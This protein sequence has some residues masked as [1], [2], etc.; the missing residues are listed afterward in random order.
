MPNL[1]MA[2]AQFCK[3]YEIMIIIDGDD[4]LLGKQGFKFY[5]AIFQKYDIWIMY[6]NFI[7]DKLF[8]AGFSWP[9]S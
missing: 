2:A 8:I 1:R 7:V 3:P 5:N 9:Y 6:S 4:Q